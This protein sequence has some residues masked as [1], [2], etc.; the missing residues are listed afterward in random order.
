MHDCQEATRGP[1]FYVQHKCIG[2]E[3]DTL[4]TIKSIAV[5]STALMTV[6]MSLHLLSFVLLALGELPSLS[7]PSA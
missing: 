3:V 2:G 4:F 5:R 6:F 1:R 7:S